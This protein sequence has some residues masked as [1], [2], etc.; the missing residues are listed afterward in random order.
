MRIRQA[1]NFNI[2]QLHVFLLVQNKV[3]TLAR[4]LLFAYQTSSMAKT[5]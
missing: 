3:L 1:H 5:N 2:L 4:I